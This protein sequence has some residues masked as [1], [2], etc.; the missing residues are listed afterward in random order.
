MTVFAISAQSLLAGQQFLGRQIA[1]VARQRPENKHHESKDLGSAQL[2]SLE[3]PASFSQRSIPSTQTGNLMHF[4]KGDR[5][6]VNAEGAFIPLSILG[7]DAKLQ[8]T[9]ENGLHGRQV[10]VFSSSGE[11]RNEMAR[12]AKADTHDCER[13]WISEHREEFK[14][15]WVALEGPRLLAS[16]PKA[17][18]VYRSARSLTSS[19]PYVVYIEENEALPF[20]GW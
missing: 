3:R 6:V 11:D 4:P 15:Q 13:R 14:G 10:V 12:L 18:E 16:G 7:S 1:G 5:I 8:Y 2:L 19:T 17:G 20:A 9:I